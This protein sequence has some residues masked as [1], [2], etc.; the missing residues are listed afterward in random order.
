MPPRNSPLKAEPR[1]DVYVSLMMVSTVALIAGNIFLAL[2]L[3]Q[4]Y[5]WSIGS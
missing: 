5:D 4:Q 2:V 3:A 1:L